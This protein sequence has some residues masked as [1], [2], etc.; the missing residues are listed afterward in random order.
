MNL[1]TEIVQLVASHLNIYEYNNFRKTSRLIN[2]SS[3]PYLNESAFVESAKIERN[4]KI[5]ILILTNFG[6]SLYQNIIEYRHSIALKKIMNLRLHLKFNADQV[7]Q[8]FNNIVNS[9]NFDVQ[10]MKLLLA[11]SRINPGIL[12]YLLR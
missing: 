11:D 4:I 5:I 8:V 6:F 1:P 9:G 7:Q 2:I 3:E 10:I 12:L